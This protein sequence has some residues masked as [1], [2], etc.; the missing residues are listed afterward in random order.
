MCVITLCVRQSHPSQEVAH[1][2]VFG[3]PQHKMPMI[4]HQ[5]VCQ[6]LARK[7]LETFRK[8]PP[9]EPPPGYPI[10]PLW[11]VAWAFRLNRRAGGLFVLGLM[12]DLIVP[13]HL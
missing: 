9:S 4:T 5:L 10:W 1:A 12:I 2:A 7:T 8:P 3:W 6:Y 13:L 11:Y